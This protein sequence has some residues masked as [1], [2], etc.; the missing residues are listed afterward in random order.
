MSCTSCTITGDIGGE[1]ERTDQAREMLGD[2]RDATERMDATTEQE[3]EDGF[4]AFAQNNNPLGE[5]DPDL[6]RG[7]VEC[8]RALADAE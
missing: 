4:I 5:E 3:A 1:R 8:F 2:E 7:L 6:V